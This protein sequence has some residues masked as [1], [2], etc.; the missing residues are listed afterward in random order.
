[1]DGPWPRDRSLRL[2][3][4]V[5]DYSGQKIPADEPVGTDGV[6]GIAR[7]PMLHVMGDAAFV[8][9]HD[10]ASLRRTPPREAVEWALRAVGSE[11]R[12]LS[13]KALDGGTSH[14]NHLL[15]IDAG[16]AVHEVV[17]RRWV[18]TDWQET[19]PAFSPAQEAATYE[20]LAS[21]AVPAPRL[22]DADVN[23]G[24]CDVPALLLTRAPG[25]RLTKPTDLGSFL[26]QLAGALPPLHGLD[27]E[28]ARGTLPP[29]RPY[30]EPE[31]LR[32]PDWTERPSAWR[33]AIEAAS[34]PEPHEPPA[35]IHR[36]YHPGNTLWAGGRLTAIVDWTTAS[37]GPRVV[38]LTHMRVN[39]A[40]FFG[41]EPAD[42]FLDAYREVTGSAV[43]LDPYWD[44]VDAV[45]FVLD[46]DPSRHSA[47]RLRGLDDFV[48]AALTRL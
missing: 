6:D 38:D 35:F 17:L 23:G 40:L 37:W 45:D 2:Y 5:R 21:S 3:D 39:L 32:V 47:T 16:G 46:L 27:P 7:V 36:D 48:A 43:D 31:G 13:I 29:Y 24:G 33:Q 12:V 41:V 4:R 1:M 10:A 15:R 25:T 9:T 42:Q 34:G 14:A 26:A 44:L 20:L 11:G 30:F 18:R 19:D 22:I 8:T 28:R